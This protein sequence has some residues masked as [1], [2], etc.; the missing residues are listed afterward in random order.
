MLEHPDRIFLDR[1]C[2]QH[3]PLSLPPPERRKVHGIVVANGAAA[4]ARTYFGAGNGSLRLVP[5]IQGEAHCFG[6]HVEPFAVG[7]V[8][9]HG[10][11]V[12]VFDETTL[13][14]V[15]SELDTITDL[16]GYL[17]KK[18]N[19][20]RAGRLVVA[21][22]EEELVAHF[23]THINLRN[24][25][26]FA[27]PDGMP[28]GANDHVNYVRG[29]YE[30]LLKNPQYL[31]KKIEDKLSYCWDHLITMFTDHMLQ[32]TSI[33]PDGQSADVSHLELGVRR[34]GAASKIR[35]SVLR[36]RRS[37]RPARR[38]ES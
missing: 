30:R 4:A 12:H 18:E 31:A 27:K 10:P 1:G 20:I 5:A 35:A 17:A 2:T 28:W 3:L 7:D 11:F 13:A 14:V 38:T 29:G 16:T 33:V 34:D 22:G 21:E 24:E 37:A 23:M 19:L 8:D 36:R 26:D 32:G 6:E 15:M 25:H 9:P